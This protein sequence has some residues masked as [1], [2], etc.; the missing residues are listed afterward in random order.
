MSGAWSRRPARWASTPSAGLA[1]RFG[2]RRPS[3]GQD[4][5]PALRR[6]LRGCPYGSK[7]SLDY[8]YLHLAEPQGAEIRAEHRVV[9]IEPLRA[10]GYGVHSR[11]PWHR[12][13]YRPLRAREVILA[14]GVLGT[15]E[16]LFRARDR[17]RT[18]PNVS[19]R[20]GQV[21]RTNREAITAVLSRDRDTDVSL[22]PAISLALLPRPGH[23]H[24][25][26]PTGRERELPA[27]SLKAVRESSVA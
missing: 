13:R 8:N 26:E 19:S 20:L 3:A 5:L 14:A 9:R 27:L 1:L 24:L 2:R 25:S 12:H 4:R 10:G 18:L 23:S 16:L 11:H 7:N 17:D 6:L 21:V 22:G 15:L